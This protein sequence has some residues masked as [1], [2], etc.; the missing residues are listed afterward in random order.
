MMTTDYDVDRL[1]ALLPPAPSGARLVVVDSIDSTNR[2]AR[3]LAGAGAAEGTLVLADR[4]TAGRGRE[5][6]GWDSPP[7]VGIWMTLIARPRVPSD[8]A[9]LLPLASGLAVAEAIEAHCAVRITLK[10]PNDLLIGGRKLAGILVESSTQGARLVWVVIGVGLNVRTEGPAFPDAIR[11]SATSLA[12][13]GVSVPSREELVAGMVRAMGARIRALAADGAH[14]LVAAFGPRDA[15]GGGS[16]EVET[17]E[18][19]TIRGR[20]LGIAPDGAL[21]LATD[22]GEIRVR[23]G[24]VRKIDP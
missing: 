3:E 15:L 1:K 9:S 12:L 13:E 17:T 4:Q 2:K 10:W 14:T 5:G 11:E 16:V 7:G 22:S 23:T 21:R 18:G 20:S 19:G 24:S 8:I 6:R